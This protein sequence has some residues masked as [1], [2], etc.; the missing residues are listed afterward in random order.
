M[1]ISILAI[2][3]NPDIL[4]TVVRLIATHHGWHG[5]GSESVPDALAILNQNPISLVLL[6]NGLTEAE[7]QEISAYCTAALPPIPV[8]QHYGGGSG[9]LESEIKFELGIN[10]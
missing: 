8:L 9:L 3:K 10:D 6:T 2:G 7:E 4:D 5:K 1:N